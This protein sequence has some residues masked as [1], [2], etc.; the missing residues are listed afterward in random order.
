[1]NTKCI[2]GKLNFIIEHDNYC[3]YNEE[4]TYIHE[5]FLCIIINLLFF[6]LLDA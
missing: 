6:P 5:S 3:M 4:C 2:F 1:M